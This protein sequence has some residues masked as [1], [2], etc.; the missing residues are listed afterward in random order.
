LSN[1]SLPFHVSSISER[2]TGETEQSGSDGTEIPSH[3]RHGARRYKLWGILFLA[4]YGICLS[5]LIAHHEPSRDEVRAY[6]IAHAAAD[7]VDLVRNRLVNEG[8]PPLWYLTLWLGSRAWDNYAVLKTASLIAGLGVASVV[9]LA[10]P[11]PLIHRCLFL[12]G[13]FPLYH[14]SLFCRGYGLA[15][16]LIL[17]LAVEYSRVPMGSP[18]RVGGYNA[19]LANTTVYGAIVAC[20]FLLIPLGKNP[21]AGL[22]R[23]SYLGVITVLTAVGLA[24]SLYT[25][26]P[27]HDNLMMGTKGMRSLQAGYANFASEGFRSL[28]AVLTDQQGW[29]GYIL[30]AYG[31]KSKLSQMGYGSLGMVVGIVGLPAIL[32]LFIRWPSVLIAF[33]FCF[34]A[35]GLF[36]MLVYPAYSY[37]IAIIG[38]FLFALLWIA[39]SRYYRAGSV[40]WRFVT[41]FLGFCL[42]FHALDGVKAVW[43][44]LH[45]PFSSKVAGAFLKEA[46]PNAVVICEPDFDVDSLP[47]YTANSIYLVRERAFGT[48]VHI[49][50]RFNRTMSLGEMM[51]ASTQ[52]RKASG[53]TVLVSLRKPIEEFQPGYFHGA[54]GRNL[55]IN[56]EELWRFRSE[57]HKVASFTEGSQTYVFYEDGNVP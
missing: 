27:N 8:H 17:L 47:Y 54:F 7:P 25:V 13:S 23:R 12:L 39:W 22:S 49:E 37:H 33:G 18:W 48:W 31:V 30:T 16:L 15:A 53:K 56:N 10:S 34:V 38:T 35:A 3:D 51:D 14:F 6:S 46:Y 2:L 52:I 44:D 20:A 42:L 4:T 19:L 5:V 36:S 41:Y 28:Y 11:F 55:E 24:L 32:A 26:W 43:G 57:F 40:Y 1:E 29:I 21:G 50:K 9:F 45:T